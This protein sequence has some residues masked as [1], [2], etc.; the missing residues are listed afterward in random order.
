MDQTIKAGDAVPFTIGGKTLTV[1]AVPYGQVKKIFKIIAAGLDEISQGGSENALVKVPR[2]MEEKVGEILP[3]LFRTGAYDFLNQEW[4]DE[5]L[6]LNDIRGIMET[7]V[8]VNGLEDF[9]AKMGGKF[10]RASQEPVTDSK[11]T[12]TV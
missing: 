12:P 8:K 6:T 4:M 2:I 11:V 10:Q 5:N 7:A 3:L 9:F 1:E